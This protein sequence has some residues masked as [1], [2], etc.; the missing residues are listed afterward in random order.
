MELAAAVSKELE[1]LHFRHRELLV[2]RH[3]NRLSFGQGRRV[4]VFPLLKH[5]AMLCDVQEKH[6]TPV[7]RDLERW[8][9]L[10]VRGV[11]Y[12]FCLPVWSWKRPERVAK[13]E[14]RGE[15][16]TWQ[17][18]DA[19][20]SGL[21]ESLPYDGRSAA[22]WSEL[23]PNEDLH[24]ADG[25]VP[26]RPV[27]AM[28]NVPTRG[29]VTEAARHGGAGS[30]AAAQDLS[31]GDRPSGPVSGE[32]VGTRHPTAPGGSSSG[33]ESGPGK[34]PGRDLF[35]QGLAA[36]RAA[37]SGEEQ[38]ERKASLVPDLG[39]RTENSAVVVPDLGTRAAENSPE[40][41]GRGGGSPGGVPFLGTT[42]CEPKGLSE[43]EL[44]EVVPKKGTGTEVA[45]NRLP[46]SLPFN[47]E[48]SSVS[49]RNLPG[50][51]KE[52]MHAS[53]PEGEDGLPRPRGMSFP[54]RETL[55]QLLELFGPQEMATWGGRWTRIWRHMPEELTEGIGEARYQRSQG[56]AW[57]GSS[58]QGWLKKRFK[59]KYLT[60]PTRK[61]DR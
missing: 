26:A 57:D 24:W 2:C 19:Y 20:L 34:G 50:E 28:I 16:A 38:E 12:G 31:G 18:L 3:V 14:L 41:R 6:L 10:R 30:C 36:M 17:E 9:V 61:D 45:I 27:S 23:F 48:R 42:F 13:A 55:A 40:E 53:A 56:G 11:L 39:T 47:V 49:G 46:L 33:I 51:K 44:P 58:L 4:A 15:F 32:S 21:D 25:P 60:V 7:L 5:L 8:G 1:R 59:E 22:A 43:G 37:V 29:F 52:G 54:L 35:A